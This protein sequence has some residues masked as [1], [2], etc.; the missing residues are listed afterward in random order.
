MTLPVPAE[1]S[2]LLSVSTLRSAKALGGRV[3]GNSEYLDQFEKICRKRN[4]DLGV[5][6]LLLFYAPYFFEVRAP[7]EPAPPEPRCFF[8][9]G[10]KQRSS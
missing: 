2:I 1:I 4:D 7:S 9:A 8:S 3:R 10:E 6:G 5:G